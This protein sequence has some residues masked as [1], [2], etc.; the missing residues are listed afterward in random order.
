[1]KN[2]EYFKLQAKNLHKDYATQFFDEDEGVYDYNPK[3]FDVN[4]IVWDFDINETEK[5]TLMNAQHIIANMVGFDKWADLIKAPDHK[6]SEVRAYLENHKS[7]SYNSTG[8]VSHNFDGL[9]QTFYRHGNNERDTEHCEEISVK[10]G[11]NPPFM[12]ECLHCGER[13]LSNKSKLI[14]LKGEP[15]EAAQEVCKNWPEC[16][17]IFWDLIPAEKLDGGRHEK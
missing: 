8:F 16:D 5:F 4:Q 3:Y 14:K 17:G 10:Q 7:N 11:D 9:E 13:F 15:D 2:I 6:L 12:V 1:M